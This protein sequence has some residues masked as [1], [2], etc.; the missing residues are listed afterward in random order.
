MR[1]PDYVFLGDLLLF[2]NLNFTSYFQMTRRA[3]VVTY[4]LSFT[5]SSNSE[6]QSLPQI[7]N[8]KHRAPCGKNS[9]MG[10]RASMNT[11]EP[12]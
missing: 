12:S 8:L 4:I 11:G 7:V 5:S 6:D 9:K 3:F 1:V 10:F 2:E